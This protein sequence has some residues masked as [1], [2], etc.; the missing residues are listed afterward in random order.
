MVTSCPP[1]PRIKRLKNS[2]RNLKITEHY[3]MIVKKASNLPHL[4]SIFLNKL[5][6]NQLKITD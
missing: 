6:K 3:S 4:S 2:G 1:T 5:I